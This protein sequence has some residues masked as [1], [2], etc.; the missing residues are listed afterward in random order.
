MLEPSP[1]NQIERES[2]SLLNSLRTITIKFRKPM[3]LGVV[4]ESWLRQEV[5]GLEWTAATCLY[6]F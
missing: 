2:N 5:L 4:G 3:K 6:F 1:E